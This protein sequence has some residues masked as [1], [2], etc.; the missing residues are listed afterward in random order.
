MIIPNINM[1]FRIKNLKLK[2]RFEELNI[3]DMIYELLSIIKT[4]RFLKFLTE[5]HLRTI[6][7]ILK[8]C[9]NIQVTQ[10]IYC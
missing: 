6:K 10:E 8:V 1:H 7:R 4:R 9:K 5:K 2:I 3:I